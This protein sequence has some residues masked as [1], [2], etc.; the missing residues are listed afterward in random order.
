MKKVTVIE[1]LT[2]A[3]E[4]Q[5]DIYK[6]MYLDPVRELLP[7]EG[8]KKCVTRE[9][10]REILTN[11]SSN[12]NY[13]IQIHNM[14][15]ELEC[16]KSLQV[17]VSNIE[18]IK[19]A[20]ECEREVL[21][22]IWDDEIGFTTVYNLMNS[23]LYSVEEKMIKY[24]ELLSIVNHNKDLIELCSVILSNLSVGMVLKNE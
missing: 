9:R 14:L 3:L 17:T 5:Q 4:C 8:I 11:I 20:V 24:R 10:V 18:L 2:R 19:N 6:D 7:P 13:L 12:V 15:S 1:V 22:D 21:D 23:Q 16:N